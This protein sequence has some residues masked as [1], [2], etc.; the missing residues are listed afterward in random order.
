L[1]Y[2][3]WYDYDPYYWDYY[4]EPGTVTFAKGSDTAEILVKVQNNGSDPDETVTIRLTDP[5]NIDGVLQYSVDSVKRYATLLIHG[6]APVAV[7]VPTVWI[8]SVVNASEPNDNSKFILKRNDSTNELTINFSFNYDRS[9]ASY[10]SDFTI[11]GLAHYWNSGTVTFAKG[12]DIAEIIVNVKDDAIVENLESVTIR[13]ND[14]TAYHL[15]S[16]KRE[17]S[18]YI[19]DNEIAPKVWIDEIIHGIEGSRDAKIILKRDHVVGALTVTLYRTGG[20]ANYS[21]D[22]NGFNDVNITFENG[23]DTAEYTIVLKEDTVVE[24]EETITVRL[25]DPAQTNGVLQYTLDET[26]RAATI[27]IHD[28]DIAPQV[29]IDSAVNAS[30]PDGNSKFILKRDDVTRELTINFSFNYDRSTASYDSDFTIAGLAN[31]W[32]PGT[33]TFAKGS[34]TAEVFVNVKDDTVVEN[35]ESVTIRLNEPNQVDGIPQY[36]VDSSRREKS[37]YII[38]NEI[39]P[40]VWID[41]II[42]GIE[43]SRD[44]K[45]ILKRD[46]VVGALTVTLYRTGGTANYSTDYNGFND[47]N[48]TF[49][50]GFDT[51]EYTI[52]LKEDAVIE[53]EE[54][55][56]VRLRDPAQTN[57]IF[58][59]TLDETK[60]AATILIYDTDIAPQVWIESVVHATEPNEQGKFI[61]KRSDVTRELTINFS[62]NYS[63]STASYD[64]DFTIAELA[65][66]WTPGTVTFAPGL[67]TAEVFVNVK[68]DTIVENWELVTIQLNDPDIVDGVIQYTVDP[69]RQKTSLYIKDNE[70][71]PNVWID[72]IIHGIEGSRDAKVILKRDHV[73]GELTVTLYRTG[74]T[75]NYS[76]DYNGFNDVNITFEDGFD[77]A[78]YTI[79]LKEDAV[80]E[81]EETITVRLR[82]P[83]QTDGVFQYTLDETKREATILI[84]DTDIVPQ[85]WI[86]SVIHATEPNGQGKFILKRSDVTHELTINFSFDYNRSTAN[87][88][89]DFTIAG[90]ASY[91]NS[92]TVTFAKGSDTAE[93]LINANED[94]IIENCETVIIRINDPNQI[95]NVLQYTL[96]ET[97]REATLYIIDNE[98]VPTVWIEEV[99]YGIEGNQNAKVILKRDITVGSLSVGLAWIGGTV[100]RWN[101]INYF[102]NTSVTFINGIATAE[103]EI[104][105][106]DDANVENDETIIVRLNEP[107][108]VNNVPQYLLH[109]TRCEATVVIK[110]NEIAPQIWIETVINGKKGDHDA[111]FVLKRSDTSRELTINFSFDY[112]QSTVSYDSDI[113]IDGLAYY[114]NSGTVTF[115]VDSDTA[116]INVRIKDSANIA[117]PESVIIRL[118]DPSSINN[119]LQYTLDDS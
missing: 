46:H 85:V 65:N 45:I 77:T 11:A 53:Q 86:D 6:E 56:T 28:T 119:I 3:E 75:A 38:D 2:E 117:Q 30:E 41:E 29:W 62:F 8:D 90:L 70:I 89:S 82:D 111:K 16:S 36:S 20:T 109:Q 42:H 88:N 87:Y 64:S 40:K 34:D 5:P 63:R 33:V 26:K 96:D 55:I 1:P 59:Y 32:N 118:N 49:E 106:K 78:E 98:I 67:D 10:D 44:A 69:K 108:Q 91:W 99:V 39:A 83:A 113:T 23:L 84:H 35:L 103:F 43:G 104:V 13:L 54:T 4:A 80:V 73:V 114:W 95:E 76:T 12:L 7:T 105:L 72:E 58:Q 18:L 110:D 101:D 25:R 71:T 24:Q 52:V 94:T 68:D 21:T 50:N 60:R 48:I 27:L 79:V 107:N 37:L 116:E 51:A 9:T 102:D 112:N 100:D 17:T 61:L 74:G 92:G 115:A 57:G 97:K 19:I 93:V 81:Q 66:S 47:V 14:S 22:Y 15:D 31:Y